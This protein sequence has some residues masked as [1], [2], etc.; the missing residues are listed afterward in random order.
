MKDRLLKILKDNGKLNVYGAG[1]EVKTYL[2]KND[3]KD[4]ILFSLYTLNGYNEIDEA[5][6]YNNCINNIMEFFE[7]NDKEII[8]FNSQD[9]EISYEV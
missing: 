3:P 9:V 4:I 2:S 1:I 7:E 5:I 6:D 8:S